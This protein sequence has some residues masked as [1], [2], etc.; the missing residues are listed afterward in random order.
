MFVPQAASTALFITFSESV[1]VQFGTFDLTIGT[2]QQQF[3]EALRF[4]AEAKE[5][6]G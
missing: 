4:P 1:T 2:G 3:A 5:L 6:P